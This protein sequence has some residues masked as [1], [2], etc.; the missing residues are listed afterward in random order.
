MKRIRY[1]SLL[2]M[3]FCGITASAQDDI[4]D[5]ESPEEPGAMAMK[6]TLKAD[7]ED[8]GSV[9][10]GGRIVPGETASLYASPYSGYDFINWTNEAGE[11]VSTEQS[12]AYVKGKGSEILTAHFAFNPESPEEPGK[13]PLRLR[14]IA[15]EGGSVSGA[16]VYQEGEAA[17]ISASPYSLYD[18][19]GWYYED[20]TLYQGA[21]H[22]YTS[23]TM[24][25]HSVTLIARFEFNPESPE[26]P[27][28]ID[29]SHK[30]MLLAEEG[31]TV[32]ASVGRLLEGESTEVRASANSGYEFV[33]WYEG[34]T[35]VSNE[36]DYTVT[37]GSSNKV[38]TAHFDYTPES[39]DEPD[40]MSQRAFTITLYN[41]YTKPGATAAF[42]ILLTPLE[43]LKDMTF[44]LNFSKTLHADPDSYELAETSKAY[45]VTYESVEDD[46]YDSYKYTLSG[47][48]MTVAEGA[49]PAVTPIL[50]FNIP[51]PED[52]ETAKSHQIKINQIIMTKADDTTQTA[53]TRNGR[54]SVYKNGDSN[55]DN[56][57][58]ISDRDNVLSKL[59]GESPSVFIEEV[60]NVNGDDKLNVSDMMGI[61]EIINGVE[62]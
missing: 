36:P 56:V 7:P 33:G 62:P 40:P 9:G 43:T 48:E 49:V 57:V 32:Y 21:E 46:V 15:E 10:G 53:G 38:L 14:L 34:D 37:M 60:S 30:L 6:L 59:R 16:G 4:F 18:F 3:L 27:S 44:Q 42:P 20:G 2:M 35:K 58:D 11:V 1:L 39:P 24:G 17:S 25:D 51:I 23:F 26:E 19:A 47:G 12:F 29:N 5:P 52:A 55:G 61:I 41:V 54:I 50:T 28:Q 13:L 31:G 45:S 22:G 8:G